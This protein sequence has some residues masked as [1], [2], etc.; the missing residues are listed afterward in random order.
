[1]RDCLNSWRAAGL[2]AIAVNGPSEITALRKLDL[3]VEFVPL[4]ADG[5][6][7]IGAILSAIRGSGAS[8]AGIINSDCKIV[9]YPDLALKLHVSLAQT[10]LAG[11]RIDIG[12]HKP[13]ACIGF[14]AYF[15]DISILP[16]DDA[17]FSIGDSWWDYWFPF[18]CEIAGA[19]I[20][21]IPVPLLTHR[22]HPLNY[23]SQDET[24]GRMRFWAA[25]EKWY[26]DSRDI[27]AGRLA[28]F[29]IAVGR[30]AHLSPSNTLN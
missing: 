5:K 21:T 8:F 26:I 24:V 27:P 13:I 22:V 7:R 15:F 9:S 1:L 17:G 20:E 18:A 30:R 11:W 12:D 16:E 2:S 3:P 23:S 4:A 10:V 25:V 29:M 28:K 14:D 6:P 19:K